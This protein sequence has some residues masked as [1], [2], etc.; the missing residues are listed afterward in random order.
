[1]ID[2]LAYGGRG[3]ARHGELVVFV[4]QRAARG[5]GAG[6][7]HQVQAPLRR[8]ACS[9]AAGGRPGTRHPPLRALRRMRRL[10]LA[11]PGLRRAAAPQA[12]A[13][14]RRPAAAGAAGGLPPGADRAGPPDLGLPQQVRVLVVADR[15]RR[16]A[17]IP[18]GRPLGPA[19]GC[20][21]LPHRIA[22]L[23]RAAPRVRAV[24]ARAGP[25]GV[26]PAQRRRVPAPPG[27]TRGPQHR[28]AAGDARHRARPGAGGRPPAANAAGWRRGGRARGQR[29]RGR[30]HG[31]AGA[32]HAVRSRRVRGADRRADPAPVAR[33]VHADQQRDVAGALPARHRAGAAVP[34]R[35]RLGPLLRCRRDRPAGGAVR[36]ARDRRRDLVRVR[37]PRPRERGP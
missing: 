20:E 29:R 36:R 19:D 11:G 14:I 16:R 33:R 6:Q 35:R 3:V 37:R 31:R 10:R 27:G 24:G 17:G 9:R 23:E 13:G 7:G 26:R 34:R 4:A 1:M 30:G 2:S 25:E 15:R 32:Y 28:P 5:Q 18:R 21:H 22:R 8:G 12:G